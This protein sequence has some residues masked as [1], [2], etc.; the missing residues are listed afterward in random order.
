MKLSTKKIFNS[1][2]KNVSKGKY[3]IPHKA[4]LNTPSI[5]TKTFVKNKVLNNCN[6]KKNAIHNSKPKTN[7]FTKLSK[8]NY[9]LKYISLT[10]Y[11]KNTKINHNSLKKNNLLEDSYINNIILTNASDNN[12]NIKTITNNEKKISMENKNINKNSSQNHNEL[13]LEQLCN[14]FKNS[15]LKSTIIVD[16]NGNNNLN[17]EQ[18]KIIND[19]FKKKSKIG[20]NSVNLF[21]RLNKRR[22]NTQIYKDHNTLF[23]KIKQLKRS[24]IET[25]DKAIAYTK[26]KE[27]KIIKKDPNKNKLSSKNNYIKI[28]LFNNRNKI[29]RNNKKMKTT[30]IEKINLVK[31]Y[32]D[33]DDTLNLDLE[34]GKRREN[35]E[36][37]SIF[38]NIS[39]ISIDSSFLGSSIEDTFYQN[40][41]KN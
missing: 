41:N 10:N 35:V 38:E 20:K 30:K 22:I 37:N 27:T 4:K 23:N 6:L 24:S 25:N 16:K 9:G 13:D 5:N 32:M 19:Y 7:P 40:L 28:N 1:Y 36:K 31:E 11:S 18:K 12:T 33:I 21:Q 29:N 17:D 8:G 26:K 14:L 39:C 3:Q 2:T 15:S 34:N